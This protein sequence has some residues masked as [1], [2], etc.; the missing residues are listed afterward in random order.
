MKIEIHHHHHE[1]EGPIRTLL[2]TIQR[3]LHMIS[4]E[5]QA[6]LDRAK[7]NSSLVQ[8]VDLGMKAL[9]Q[10]VS[11]L[12]AQIAAMPVGNVL[13]DE[14][15]AAL[16]EAASNLDTSIST[17]KDDIPANTPPANGQTQALD[18]NGQP[19]TGGTPQADSNAAQGSIDGTAQ[20]GPQPL[21][22]TGQS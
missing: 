2:L 16:T 18:P 1:P 13:S 9:G 15:K 4:A 19:A 21:P 10:Q 8:S 22:G 7:Q 17:L 12:K 5:V 20:G 6:I 11:D 14:D 3:E